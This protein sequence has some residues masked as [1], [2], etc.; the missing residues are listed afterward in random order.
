ME[1]RSS[2]E[3]TRIFDLI[4]KMRKVALTGLAGVELNVAGFGCTARGR[5]V[6]TGVSCC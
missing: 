6:T 5:V 1:L 2:F 4:Y 3:I